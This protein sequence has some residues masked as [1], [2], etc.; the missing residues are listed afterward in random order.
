MIWDGLPA[1]RSAL[2]RAYLENPHGAA[3]IE[4]LPGYATEL[5]PTE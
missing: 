2:M 1:H 4:Q 5:N 3:Q